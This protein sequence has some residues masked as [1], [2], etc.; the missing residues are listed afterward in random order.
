MGPVTSLG[1][2]Q[3]LGAR[4]RVRAYVDV[5][6]AYLEV[7]DILY[8]HIIIHDK[9]GCLHIFSGTVDQKCIWSHAS[10]GV[11]R[12]RGESTGPKTGGSP[13]STCPRISGP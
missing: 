3:G 13:R 8:G 9:A 1:L 2:G 5:R 6:D 4:A 11:H 10:K 7:H 12:L